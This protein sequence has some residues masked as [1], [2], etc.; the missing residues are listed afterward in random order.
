MRGKWPYARCFVGFCSKIWS[1]YLVAFLCNCRQ[2]FSQNVKSAS[3]WC[4][5]RVVSSKVLETEY[6]SLEAI[7]VFVILVKLQ[8][9]RHHWYCRYCWLCYPCAS[10]QT[11]SRTQ[12][13]LNRPKK[14]K[15]TKCRIIRTVRSIKIAHSIWNKISVKISV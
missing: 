15:K 4:I 10:G 1:I 12:L 5:H 3:M 13:V 6:L 7:C 9:I 8:T 11:I 14:F 2:A